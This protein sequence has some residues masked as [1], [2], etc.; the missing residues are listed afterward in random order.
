LG[1][2]TDE[3]LAEL[4]LNESEISALRAAGVAGEEN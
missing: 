2:N 4:G 3:I 1:E